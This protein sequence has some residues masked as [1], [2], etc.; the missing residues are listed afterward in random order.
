MIF[1]RL[2]LLPAVFYREVSVDF[3]SRDICLV[4]QDKAVI[5]NE[6]A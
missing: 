2:I 3:H 5:A 4:H 1:I 6:R